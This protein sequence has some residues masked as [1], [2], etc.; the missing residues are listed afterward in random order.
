MYPARPAFPPGGPGLFAGTHTL[1]H[2][3]SPCSRVA[4]ERRAWPTTCRG[5]FS[6]RNL[7]RTTLR[8]LSTT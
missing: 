2:Q 6:L 7:S 4:V 1:C 5:K 3:G 8:G